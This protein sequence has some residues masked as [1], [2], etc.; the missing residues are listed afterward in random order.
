MILAPKKG[1]PRM[2]NTTAPAPAFET[3]NAPPSAAIFF[4]N[5][6][7]NAAFPAVDECDN[8]ENIE[9]ELDTLRKNMSLGMLK[10]KKLKT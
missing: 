8:E 10:Q 6:I 5:S 9:I 4:P 2:S 7:K 1:S 3:P